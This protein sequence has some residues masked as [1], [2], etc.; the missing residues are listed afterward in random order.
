MAI[1]GIEILKQ[2][3]IYSPMI[4][5]VIFG[6]L[7]LVLAITFVSSACIYENVNLLIPAAI[8]FITSIIIIAIS[9]SN[10]QNVLTKPSNI[11]YV[12]EIKDDNAWKELGLNYTIKE[13]VYE[14]KEI[15]LVEGDYVK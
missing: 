8:F 4:F 3:T 12:I 6:V 15:Y 11:E 1:N 5:S 7:C 10:S 2:T 14:N 9:D 13:K